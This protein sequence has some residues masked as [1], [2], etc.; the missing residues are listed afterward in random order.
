MLIIHGEDKVS[1]YKRLSEI[2]DSFRKR[3]FEIIFFDSQDLDITTLSQA[4]SDL[5]NAL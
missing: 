1:S 5:I 3:Q 4:S 2:I